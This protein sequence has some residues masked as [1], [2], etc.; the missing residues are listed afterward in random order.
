MHD[1]VILQELASVNYIASES[2]I[3]G[4]SINSI[5]LDLQ[6]DYMWSDIGLNREEL[7]GQLDIYHH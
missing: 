2:F 1:T 3:N 4:A 7:T 5:V 6:F